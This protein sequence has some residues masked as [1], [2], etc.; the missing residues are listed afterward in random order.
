L[1]DLGHPD[2]RRQPALARLPRPARSHRHPAAEG[3]A[4]EPDRHR[5]PSP[6]RARVCQLVRDRDQNRSGER[7][8]RVDPGQPRSDQ[9][10]GQQRGHHHERDDDE[11]GAARK[12]DGADRHNDHKRGQRPRRREN[13][14]C[15]HTKLSQPAT[16]NAQPAAERRR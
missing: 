1:R 15:G 6:A 2:E 7:A 12:V 13:P 11:S 9:G 3:D 8:D 4:G 10:G 14:C 5:Q 16:Q